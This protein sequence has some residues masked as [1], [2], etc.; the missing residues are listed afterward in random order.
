[1]SAVLFEQGSG[2]PFDGDAEYQSTVSS[3]WPRSTIRGGD[4]AAA[5][6][7]WTEVEA[8]VEAIDHQ[9]IAAGT[10]RV[11]ARGEST[12]PIRPMLRMS[13]TFGRPLS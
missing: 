8:T 9:L 10:R 5:S 7:L 6:Q 12:A 1:M 2:N 11:L 3:I 13:I 4:T